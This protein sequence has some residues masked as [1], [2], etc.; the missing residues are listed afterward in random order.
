MKTV[1]NPAFEPG[2]LDAIVAMEG[3]A[4]LIVVVMAV[5]AAF[6]FAERML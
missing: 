3:A 2:L 6:M 4:P 1:T 5:F